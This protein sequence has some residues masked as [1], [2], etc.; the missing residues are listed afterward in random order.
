LLIKELTLPRRLI[1]T[2][3]L[4]KYLNR[5]HPTYPELEKDLAKRWAGY[6]GEAALANYLQELPQEK[7]L[8]L[9]DLHLQLHDTHFQIDTLLIAP[10]HILIIE[11]KNIIG[12]LY[13][14][15]IFNQLIRSNPDG[16]E[17]SFEDPRTQCRRLQSL[18]KRWLIQH[19]L[20]LLSIDYLIFFKS[21]NKTILKTNGTTIDTS[22]ICKGRDLFT[23]IE[24]IEKQYKQE[25]IQAA[26][27][28]DIAQYLVS[29][30]SPKQ[31]DILQEYG[32]TVNDLPWG[33]L[34]QDCTHPMHYQKGIWHCPKC[35]SVSK[36]AHIEAIN[37]HFLLIKPTITNR[38]CQ[39]ILRLPTSDV[40]RRILIT[41]DLPTTGHTKNRVYHQWAGDKS[42]QLMEEKIITQRR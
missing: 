33:V 13:I 7:Y 11:A 36:D 25:K 12:T 28:M 19:N 14:D 3:T 35:H 32:L 42:Y 23:K 22:R 41:L 30:H 34:C 17:D 15:N 4:K 37:D 39:T 27:W 40:T 8:I 10:T 5:N 18:L 29:R 2:L 1:L 6:W 9:H 16:T 24:S 20:H 21:T 31:I 26:K 38:E